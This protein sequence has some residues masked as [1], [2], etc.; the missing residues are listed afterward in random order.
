[1]TNKNEVVTG[2][3]YRSLRERDVLAEHDITIQFNLDG[4]QLFHSSTTSMWPIQV[5]V[6]ELPYKMRRDNILLCG[7]WYGKCKPKMETYLKFLADELVDLHEVGITRIDPEGRETLIKVHAIMCSVDS[8]ARPLLQNLHQYNGE[9]GCPFCLSKGERIAVGRGFSRVYPGDV[10]TKRT[11]V[12]HEADCEEAVGT[13]T[14]VN[15][16]KGPSILML[17]PIFHIIF[18][19]V[20][21]YMHC[22]LLGVTKTMTNDLFDSSNSHEAWYIGTKVQDFDRKLESMKPPSEI[23]RTPNSVKEIQHWKASE[24][25][26]YLLYYSLPCLMNILP[27]KYVQHWFLLVY[28]M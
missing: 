9:F 18:S 22:V 16:V 20:P 6:N 21:D 28:S 26:N 23:T 24:C 12:Q 19:F 17:V 7:V 11:I 4:V 15:G 3:L 27:L 25:K 2:K 13:K 1:M 5:A 10:G 14:I 8:V